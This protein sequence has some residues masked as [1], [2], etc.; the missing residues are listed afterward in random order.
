[1]DYKIGVDVGTT[2]TKVVLFDEDNVAI[3]SANVGYKTYHDQLNYA[4]Q[5]PNEILTAFKKALREVI[6]KA[7][8]GRVKLLAFSSA[9]HSLILIDK[10]GNPLTRCIIWSDNRAVRVV[11]EYKKNEEWMALY[12]RTG[13]PV[14]PMS[15]FFKLLWFKHNSNLLD[16]AYKIIGI[17]E[18]IIYELTGEYILDYSVASATGM[19]NIHNMTWDHEALDYLSIG[20]EKLSNLV[21]VTTKVDI[22]NSIFLEEINLTEGAKILVGASDGCLANLGSYAMEKGETTVTL[23]T[24]GAVRM[25]VEIPRLDSEGRTFCYYLSPGKW[26]IGGA[27]NNGG[28]ILQWLEKILYV[29]EGS[30]YQSLSE[31]INTIPIGSDGLL[32][33]PFLHGE[34]APVWDGSLRASFLE[35]T[36]YH[37]KNHFI[38]AALEGI[39]FN[40]REVWE[41]LQNLEG[42]STKI[43][44][45]GGFL[46]NQ[47]GAEML[48]DIFG[49]NYRVL[50][51]IESNCLGA[52]L[53]DEKDGEYPLPNLETISYR[54]KNH[55]EYNEVYRRYYWFSKKLKILH[56]EAKIIY[57]K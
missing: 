44:A 12:E 39:I 22:T 46:K 19:F 5:D 54:M 25:T 28:N 32:F 27:V 55:E 20:V 7:N 10:E 34:R 57:S 35:I 16:K 9:M 37:G 40:L 29:E 51:S 50:Q 8:S 43:V 23:G 53:L 45:S 21:E 18:Y 36:A 15:P 56:E 49:V 24:S 47:D 52:V 2:S 41:I 17:K 13:T 14:H 33:L 30:I 1:M 4:E 3:A 26:V 31:S 11:E 48:A 42:K 6:P 38:R